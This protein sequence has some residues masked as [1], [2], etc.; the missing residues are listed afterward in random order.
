MIAKSP[1]NLLVATQSALLIVIHGGSFE[2]AFATDGAS[3][4][5]QGGELSGDVGGGV[6][7]PMQQ[8]IG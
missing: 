2:G 6:C 5:A 7:S 4:E 1:Q 8:K 3:G